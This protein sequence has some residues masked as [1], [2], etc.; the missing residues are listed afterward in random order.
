MFIDEELRQYITK[1][2]GSNVDIDKILDNCGIWLTLEELSKEWEDSVT[3]EEAM[4]QTFYI[5]EKNKILFC[6]DGLL[7]DIEEFMR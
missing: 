5:V 3:L 1:E 4:Y 2:Y 6:L 7:E